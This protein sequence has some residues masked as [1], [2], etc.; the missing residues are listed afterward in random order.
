MSMTVTNHLGINGFLE[1]WFVL[2]HS[3]WR[4]SLWPMTLLLWACG[5]TVHNSKNMWPQRTPINFIATKE[6]KRKGISVSHNSLQG[7]APNDLE[8]PAGLH[9]LKATPPPNS[10]NTNA[11]VPNYIVYRVIGSFAWDK[12]FKFSTGTGMWQT[13]INLGFVRT[14]SWKSLKGLSRCSN[15]KN[16]E[17][18]PIPR[19]GNPKR[20]GNSN[21]ELNY[22]LH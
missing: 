15:T 13:C 10:T 4:F 17:R 8:L 20:N 16:G 19:F 1:K 22:L 14:W 18:N 6:W 9:L 7:L 3:L 12:V 2:A 11:K 5:Y 21:T